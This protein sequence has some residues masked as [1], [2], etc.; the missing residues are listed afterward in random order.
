MLYP[1][2]YLFILIIC[3]ALFFLSYPQVLYYRAVATLTINEEFNEDDLAL[4]VS[5][6]EV[7][8]VDGQQV[9]ILGSVGYNNNSTGNSTSQKPEVLIEVFYNGN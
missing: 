2:L 3:S 6:D 4:S 1:R 8:Y 9:K 7:K 5:T